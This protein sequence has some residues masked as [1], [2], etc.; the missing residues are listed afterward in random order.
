MITA[1]FELSASMDVALLRM[2]HWMRQYKWHW[3]QYS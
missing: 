2:K 1:V 3:R